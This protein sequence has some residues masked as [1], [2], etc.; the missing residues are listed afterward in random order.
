M[1]A[2]NFD[3]TALRLLHHSHHR[4]IALRFSGCA[5]PPLR[6]AI[7]GQTRKL[8]RVHGCWMPNGDS[9][10]ILRRFRIFV[11]SAAVK[12]GEKWGY[13]DRTGA[14]AITPRF[15]GAFNFSDGLASV[16]LEETT[17]FWLHR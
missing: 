10:S 13:L 16:H 9:A 3:E 17:P 12:V 4:S 8:L 6:P 2:E 1:N 7:F 14:M 11:G 15:A 5:L